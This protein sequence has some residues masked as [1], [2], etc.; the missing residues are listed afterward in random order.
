MP[1][2]PTVILVAMICCACSDPSTAPENGVTEES[3]RTK[4][5]YEQSLER[6]REV[7]DQ[8]REAAERTERAI[9]EIDEGGS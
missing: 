8:T 1:R 7:E 2:S 5:G 4:T 3:N 6:A 9:E